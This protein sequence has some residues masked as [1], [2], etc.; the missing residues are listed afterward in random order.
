MERACRRFWEVIGSLQEKRRACLMDPN[1]EEFQKA[2]VA[3]I[4]NGIAEHQSGMWRFL[5]VYRGN[6]FGKLAGVRVRLKRAEEC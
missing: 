3:T 4:S 2:G 1:R 6:R 5:I